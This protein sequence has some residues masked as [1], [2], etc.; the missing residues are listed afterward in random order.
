MICLMTHLTSRLVTCLASRLVTRLATACRVI[1]KVVRRSRG[2]DKP[3]MDVK[4]ADGAVVTFYN[5]QHTRAKRTKKHIFLC[6]PEVKVLIVDDPEMWAE[7]T[8]PP[9]PQL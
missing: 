8:G 6:N 1:G 3:C 9:S 4:F 5:T 2:T 7:P